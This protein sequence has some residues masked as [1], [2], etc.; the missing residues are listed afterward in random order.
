MTDPSRQAP[1]V[2]IERTD[3]AR[4]TLRTTSQGKIVGQHPSIREVVHTVERVASSNCTVLITGENGTGKE[5][6]VAVLHDASLRAKGPVVTVNCGT[7]PEHLIEAQLFGHVRGAYT[8]AVTAS[9]GF[10]ATAEGG[11]LFLDEVGELPLL[12]QVKFLRLLQ[13]R[14]YIPVGDTKTVR[15]DI[16]VVAAT[17]RNLEVEVDAGRFREDL[18]YRINVVHVNL[19][20]LRERAGDIELL[21]MHFLRMVTAR[22]SRSTPTGIDPQAMRALAAYP[23]PGNI[24]QLENVIERAVLLAPAGLVTLNDLPPRVR[25]HE[26]GAPVRLSSLPPSETVGIIPPGA[27]LGAL[28]QARTPAEALAVDV[29]TGDPPTPFALP[30]LPPEGVDLAAA[31]ESFENSL[32]RQA[33]DRTGGNRNRAAQVLR[34]NRTTLI[35]KIRRKRLGL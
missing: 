9:Q 25:D 8:G 18:Y 21:A 15:C 31:M 29:P 10:V 3:S 17:N 35:E 33:L 5:L 1:V 13:Q 26:P 7:I 20:P 12:M 34:I 30:V 16:R 32:I 6:V 11:T 4:S 24:R 14:E 19:P 22:N 28:I 23:W 2:P 27:A